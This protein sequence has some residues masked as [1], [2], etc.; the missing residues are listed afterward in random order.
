[1]LRSYGGEI[2]NGGFYPSGANHA[3]MPIVVE[4]VPLANYIEWIANKIQESA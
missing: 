2:R 4:A 1:M 3:F